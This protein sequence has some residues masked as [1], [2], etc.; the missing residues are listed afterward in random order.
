MSLFQ[1]CPYSFTHKLTLSLPGVESEAITYLTGFDPT[2]TQLL[3]LDAST[4]PK[5]FA[6]MLT[7]YTN[8][9]NMAVTRPL[10]STPAALELGDGTSAEGVFVPGV[11]ALIYHPI[12]ICLLT[13]SSYRYEWTTAVVLGVGSTMV[14]DGDEKA[15]WIFRSA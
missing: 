12:N 14:L 11:C 15:V 13:I 6:D 10:D 8:I 7:T 1:C 5:P 2:V 4:D 3:G 9:Q